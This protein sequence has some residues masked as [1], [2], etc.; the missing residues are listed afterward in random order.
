MVVNIHGYFILWGYQY[1]LAK[2]KV[3]KY[4]YIYW[5]SFHITTS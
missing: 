4:Y 5:T 3:L 1:N 2:S